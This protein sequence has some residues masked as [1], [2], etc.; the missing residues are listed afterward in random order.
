[1]L[2]GSSGREIEGN[3]PLKMNKFNLLL[4]GILLI[5]ILIIGFGCRSFFSDRT[6]PKSRQIAGQTRIGP[7]WIEL[8]PDDPLVATGRIQLIGL[9]M[10]NIIERGGEAGEK[11][12]SADGSEFLLE[13]ELIGEDGRATSLFPNGIGAEFIEFG[14]RTPD[15]ENIDGAY[16]QIGEKFNRIRV[17]SS[18]E[19]SAAEIVWMEF[20]F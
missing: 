5:F 6:P 7:D 11:L 4:I 20:E 9:K 8:T 10:P 17:R 3:R 16:F 19:V 14:K 2:H 18:K 15:K 1:M 13:V 12:R